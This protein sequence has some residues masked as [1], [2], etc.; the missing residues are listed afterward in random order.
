MGIIKSAEALQYRCDEKIKHIQQ[1]FTNE[2]GKYHFLEK[3]KKIFLGLTIIFFTISDLILCYMWFNDVII[4]FWIL[5]PCLGCFALLLFI[6][7]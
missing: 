7:S 6:I 3:D 4:K 5:P 1:V 2:A